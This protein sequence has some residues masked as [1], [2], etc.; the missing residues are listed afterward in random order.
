MPRIRIEFFKGDQ[1]R[2]LSHLD[3]VKTFER[4]VRR[5]NLP[6][7]YSEG[8]NP[9][10]KMNFASALAVG[11]TSDKEYL[12]IELKNEAD[13]EKLAADLKASL[14]PGINVNSVKY[15]KSEGP[16]LMGLINRAQYM[17]EAYLSE[18]IDKSDVEN[19][20][21]SFLGRDEIFVLKWTKKGQREKNI[22]PGIIDFT[23]EID[24]GKLIFLLTTMTGSEGNVRPE[25]VIKAFQETS[26]IPFDYENIYI[27]RTGLFT[28]KDNKLFNP[29]EL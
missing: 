6:I 4:A 27:R 23:V 18:P 9:H 17:V 10:P 29:M 19:K 7:V 21:K 20:I 13:L 24:R 2:F 12:D 15:V 8:F 25:E 5:I 28:E 1:V 22:R 3:L 16:A 11:V 26:G 14:P